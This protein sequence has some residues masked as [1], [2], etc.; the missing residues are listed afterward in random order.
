MIAPT[1][2]LGSILPAG[3]EDQKSS[4][5]AFSPPLLPL[6]LPPTLLEGI[7]MGSGGVGWGGVRLVMVVVK[8]RVT[9]SSGSSRGKCDG[10]NRFGVEKAGLAKSR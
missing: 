3:D 2:Y 1:L 5:S 9:V 10:W 4:M 7:G 8:V 6:P